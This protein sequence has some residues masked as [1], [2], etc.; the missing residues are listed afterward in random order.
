MRI[1]IYKISSLHEKIS[2]VNER[3]LKILRSKLMLLNLV[4]SVMI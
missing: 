1:I 3:H 2:F 4:P